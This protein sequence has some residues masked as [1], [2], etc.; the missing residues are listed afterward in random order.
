MP[1]GEGE[2]GSRKVRKVREGFHACFVPE[3]PKGRGGRGSVRAAKGGQRAGGRR[4]GGSHRGHREH[5]ESGKRG[6]QGG[7]RVGGAQKNKKTKKRGMRKRGGGRRAGEGA[8]PSAP[9]RADKGRKGAGWS[10]QGECGG[11]GYG[12][13]A[14]KKAGGGEKSFPH[15]GNQFRGFFHTMEACFGHFS[16]QWKRV[17]HAVEKPAPGRRQGRARLRPRRKGRIT[18]FPR[19]F[20][21]WGEPSRRAASPHPSSPR[22]GGDASPHRLIV[23]MTRYGPS[24]VQSPTERVI[25][26]REPGGGGW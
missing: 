7:K 2:K 25:R 8:A 18:R 21:R 22:L 13:E 3:A 4:E 12:W 20:C 19:G 6:E 23:G 1:R 16:T 5:K 17:F 24:G 26:G 10:W 11:A 14:E 15:N 9:Q